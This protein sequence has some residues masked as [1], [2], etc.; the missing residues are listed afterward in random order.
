MRHV[1]ITGGGTGIGFAVAERFARAGDRVTITG[2]RENV[3]REAAARLGA[4]ASYAA[5]DASDPAAVGA[6]LPGLPERVDVLAPA[7]TARRRP[8]SRHGPPPSPP[9]SGR[10]A[11]RPT[12]SRPATR[13]AASS[14]ATR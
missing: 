3:L 9:S 4:S 5:F 6:A 8:R 7:P 1:V 13:P 10:A 14:S 11:S 2:R 12:R